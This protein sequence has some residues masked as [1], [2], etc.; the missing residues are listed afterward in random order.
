ML[1]STHDFPMIMGPYL[2]PTVP[3]AL[4]RLAYEYT[5][6]YLTLRAVMALAET[7]SR[8]AGVDSGRER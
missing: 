2:F 4:R 3:D 1:I 5:A 8:V 6:Q 7:C